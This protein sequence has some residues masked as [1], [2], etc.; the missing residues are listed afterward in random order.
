MERES[1][2]LHYTIVLNLTN[3]EFLMTLKDIFKF[4]WL[5]V[6]SI[7][8]YGIKNKQVVRLRLIDNKKE[9]HVNLLYL[10]DSHNDNLGHF[11]WI[12]NLSRLVSS[13]ITRKKNKKFFCDR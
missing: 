5:K 2:Y 10:Q 6:V 12:K 7:N 8:V 13:Q 1:S 4:E 9:K 11:A 3:I